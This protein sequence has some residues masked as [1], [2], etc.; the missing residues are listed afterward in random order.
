MKKVIAVCV[1]SIFLFVFQNEVFAVEKNK[2]MV[3]ASKSEQDYLYNLTQQE[4]FDFYKFFKEYELTILKES[5][6][7]VYTVDMLKYAESGELEVVPLVHGATNNETN[8]NE[9][10]VFVAKVLTSKNEYGGNI[11][12]Y[13]ENN[14]AYS[15]GY[16]PS[17]FADPEVVGDRN[18]VASCSFVDHAQRIQNIIG[19]NSAVSVYDVK[20]VIIDR[21]GYFFYIDNQTCCG[22]VPVGHHNVKNSSNVDT[23]L[24]ENELKNIA[25]EQLARYNE[26]KAARELWEK[27]HPGER[28]DLTG[29]YSVEPIISGCSYVDNIIDIFSYIENEMNTPIY[30]DIGGVLDNSN[31]TGDVVTTPD[32]SAPD[33]NVPDTNVPDTNVPDTN[34]PDTNTPDANVTDTNE[35]TDLNTQKPTNAALWVGVTSAAVVLV[36]GAVFVIIKL[37][38]R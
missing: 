13:V 23:F 8:H 16:L 31:I 24:S 14:T 33:T 12:F 5:I 22:M 6:S 21:I 18:Y 9:G 10:N 7:V 34:V 15:W 38:K 25:E 20:Y 29:G 36:A 28:Y 3:Y 32:T 17:V 2:D 4:S 1:L 30:D 35:S 19:K 27:E 11:M 37:R 26:D